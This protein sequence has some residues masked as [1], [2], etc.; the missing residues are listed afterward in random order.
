MKRI[1]GLVFLLIVLIKP[2]LIQAQETERIYMLSGVM[3]TAAGFRL[4]TDHTFEYFFSYGAADKWGKGTWKRV[5]S[6]IIFTSYHQQ[7]EQ[8]FILK[9]A[10]KTKND[11]LQITVA[12]SIH[13]PYRYV[14]CLLNDNERSTN[15]NGIV[16]YPAD[17]ARYLRMYHPIFSIRLTTINLPKDKN[18]FIIGPSC[19][20]SEV[21]FNNLV[22]TASPNEI[23]STI[24][25]GSPDQPIGSKT[26]HF[27][28]EQ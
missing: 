16:T 15:E 18:D 8:D 22:F 1:Y 9:E 19:D 17:S 6:L 7:P 5:D 11:F 24:L 2:L 3:E 4:L 27:K 20:L 21:F 13:N 14:A 25:P 12:D 26:F 28:A 23:T 10:K